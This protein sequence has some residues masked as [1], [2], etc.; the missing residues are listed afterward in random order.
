MTSN[1]WG[2]TLQGRKHDNIQWRWKVGLHTDV[3]LLSNVA[4]AKIMDV[5]WFELKASNIRMTCT[6][7]RYEECDNKLFEVNLEKKLN[8]S[9]Y[10]WSCCKA[11]RNWPNSNKTTAA[12][13]CPYFLKLLN[14]V[15][16]SD[17]AKRWKEQPSTRKDTIQKICMHLWVRIHNFWGD[18]NKNFDC[19]N[20]YG[21]WDQVLLLQCND[22]VPLQNFDDQN[23]HFLFVYVAQQRLQF[24]SSTK[25]Q[26]KFKILSRVT[27]WC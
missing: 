17:P 23:T 1:L 26:A 10:I 27:K 18:S 4:L 12:L 24:V 7:V 16:K 3:T 21:C 22:T 11:S 13:K 2:G 8:N 6:N 19:Y 20:I 15:H 14:R 5:V 9:V 25:K